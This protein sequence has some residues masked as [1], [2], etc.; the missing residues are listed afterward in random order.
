MVCTQLAHA[1]TTADGCQCTHSCSEVSARAWQIGRVTVVEHP[2]PSASHLTWD[3]DLMA[4]CS[5]GERA[6]WAGAPSSTGAAERVGPCAGG[7]HGTR[8]QTGVRRVTRHTGTG[9]GHHGGSTSRYRLQRVGR[10]HGAGFWIWMSKNNVR[11]C[12]TAVPPLHRGGGG[13]KHESVVS[14][15][16][17]MLQRR[18]SSR[19]I[20]PTVT[21]LP[22]RI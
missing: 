5:I 19:D 2:F 14:V 3:A 1:H 17:H 22:Q 16:G 4:W 12:M 21:L 13:K 15:T 11:A 6:A 7:V 8:C 18:L 9:A 20:Q 10:R